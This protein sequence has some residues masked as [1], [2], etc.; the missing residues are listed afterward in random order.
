MSH[1]STKVTLLTVV[2]SEHPLAAAEL[3]QA[4]GASVEWV[5]QLVEL[6]IVDCRSEAKTPDAWRFASADLQRALETRRL[7]RDFGVE[8]EAAALILDLQQ[9][10]RRLKAVLSQHGLAP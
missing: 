5:V 8:L 3:A 6:G 7:E 1:F 2:S 10:V 9:E 4:C